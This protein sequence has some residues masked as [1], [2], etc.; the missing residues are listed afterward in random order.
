MVF[1]SSA[2]EVVLPWNL[3]FWLMTCFEQ[4]IA[5]GIVGSDAVLTCI[6]IPKSQR[7]FLVQS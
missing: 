2:E 7:N 3:F 5:C 4:S 1:H 6:N